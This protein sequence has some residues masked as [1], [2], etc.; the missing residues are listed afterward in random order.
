MAVLKI[1]PT[2]SGATVKA[3]GLPSTT[4]RYPYSWLIYYESKNIGGLSMESYPP[5]VSFNHMT[6][7][8]TLVLY[9]KRNSTSNTTIRENYSDYILGFQGDYNPTKLNE[10]Q[11]Y[12]SNKLPVID[13][14]IKDKLNIDYGASLDLEK[15]P[16]PEPSPEPSPDPSPD[17]SPGFPSFPNMGDKLDFSPLYV[18]NIK[19]KFPFSLPWDFKRVIDIFD[20]E[21]I[22]P[23]FEVPLV[24]ETIEI[25]FSYFEEWATIIRFFITIIFTSTLIFISTKLKG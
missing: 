2:T 6:T 15:V 10:S 3:T 14:T 13:S 9:T 24:T 5:S 19:D 17:P 4:S 21:P 8:D 16:S 20:V 12:N 22:A 25:D 23:R 7:S 11:I 18:T 1:S